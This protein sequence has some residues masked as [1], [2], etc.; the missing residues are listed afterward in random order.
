MP[1]LLTQLISVLAP[2]QPAAAGGIPFPMRRPDPASPRP[3]DFAMPNPL[4][5]FDPQTGMFRGA[6]AAANQPAVPPLPTQRPAAAVPPV[7][8]RRP[9]P[10]APPL[11]VRRPEPQVAGAPPLPVRRHGLPNLPGTMVDTAVPPSP[12]GAPSG[13]PDLMNVA[14]QSD[15]V[16]QLRSVLA[17][18]PPPAAAPA[19]T[20][21]IGPFET[22]VTPAQS[23]PSI[24]GKDVASF[25]RNLARGAATVDPTAPPLS[26]FARGMAGSMVGMDKES[27]E[28]RKAELEQEDREF[29]RRMKTTDARLRQSKDQREAR[30]AEIA[31]TKAV[32]EIMRNLGGDLT[33]DQKFKMEGAI[34]DF[35]KA[36]NP[37][38]ILTPEELKPQLE[39][40]RKEIEG[41]ITGRQ[42]PAASGAAQSQFREGQTATGPNGQKIVFRNGKWQPLS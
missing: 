17:G 31:N 38:G 25:F 3:A 7:P 41:R 4:S 14:G 33:T 15:L 5:N 12:P 27:R 19:E 22:T 6:P 13:M 35:A 42:S 2:P 29:E 23:G 10:A 40:Y 37:T 9:D 36:I 20:A 11:P 32:T 21:S 28:A 16:S 39:E 24:T 8:M 18:G 26:A 30:S 34:R 1:D